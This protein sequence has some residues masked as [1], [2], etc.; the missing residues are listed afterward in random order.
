MHGTIAEWKQKG[1]EVI[2][3]QMGEVRETTGQEPENS[4]TKGLGE[5]HV[6]QNRA[7]DIR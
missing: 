2:S 3:C 5:P 1:E 6:S 4:Q 7:N